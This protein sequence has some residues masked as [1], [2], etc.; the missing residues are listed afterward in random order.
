MLDALSELKTFRS[1]DSEIIR[2]ITWLE[3][4]INIELCNLKILS[5]ELEEQEESLK[6]FLDEYCA[7]VGPLFEENSRINAE[8]NKKNLRVEKDAENK[9]ENSADAEL[10][11]SYHSSSR[12]EIIQKEAK[13]LYRKLVKKC[14]PDTA[15][16]PDAAAAFSL[17]SSSYFEKD[18]STLISIEQ[19]F[20]GEAERE[21]ETFI[22]KLERLERRYNSILNEVDRLKWKKFDLE[23]SEEYALQQR[24]CWH[25]MCGDNLIERIKGKVKKQIEKKL[26]LLDRDTA[27]GITSVLYITGKPEQG[28]IEYKAS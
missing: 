25:R 15:S 8:L 4:Q 9:D 22:A 20:A 7:E 24:V 1:P 28:K 10:N 14:H 19:A 23:N 2:Q 11:F 13:K 26:M 3:Q 5:A 12:E 21:E 16:D 27:D 17:L 18:L 6:G